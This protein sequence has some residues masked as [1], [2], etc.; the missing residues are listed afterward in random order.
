MLEILVV[1]TIIAILI[2]MGLSSYR[3]SRQRSIEVSGFHGMKVLG[4]AEE[5]Y[6]TSY[7][8]YARNFAEL[9]N[10]SIIAKAYRQSDPIGPAGGIDAF[11]RGFS[12]T[13]VVTDPTAQKFSIYAI[14]RDYMYDTTS[15]DN[16]QFLL[17]QEGIV[18][19]QRVGPGGPYVP[20]H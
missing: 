12:V 14:G 4:A 2:T 8:R 15:G 19:E 5:A 7:G 18:M 13:F 3:A 16:I 1:T 11:M 17:T 10:Y 6:H 20:A 9:Q